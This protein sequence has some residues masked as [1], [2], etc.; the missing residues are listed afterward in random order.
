VKRVIRN[1]RMAAAQ[2]AAQA[3]LAAGT[4]REAETLLRR[5]LRTEL[6]GAARAGGLPA[7]S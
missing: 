7:L 4:A 5:R 1:V 3:A 6:D 2:D